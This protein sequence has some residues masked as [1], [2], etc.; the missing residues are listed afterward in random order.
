MFRTLRNCV[1]LALAVLP[2]R[3]AEAA[4]F[5]G[6]PAKMV[7]QHEIAVEESYSF[8]RTS[9][10]VKRLVASGALVPVPAN[11]DL[12]LTRVSFPFARP[13]VRSFVEH[14][15]ARYHA[16]TGERLVVTSLTRPE[17]AQPRNAHALSVHPAGMAVDLRVPAGSANRAWFERTLAEMQKDGAID[18][19]RERTPPHYHIA[20]FTAR[21]TPFAARQDSVAAAERSALAAAPAPV[22]PVATRPTAPEPP[23]GSLAGFLLSMAALTGLTIPA[24]RV[25][26]RKDSGRAAA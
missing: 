10:D 19:T 17:V 12:V 25:V 26:H 11:A 22:S 1:T 20:V 14:F 9:A 15:A 3:L 23:D 4:D 24:L 18:V 6:T 8:L 7:R 2:L 21:W 5:R 13:E 16:A